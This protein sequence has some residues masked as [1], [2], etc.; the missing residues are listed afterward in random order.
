MEAVQT[1]QLKDVE[2][3]GRYRSPTCTQPSDTERKTKMGNN[4]PL[5][6]VGRARADKTPDASQGDAKS[7][8]ESAEPASQGDAK[9]ERK[10][11][12]PLPEEREDSQST[13]TLLGLG[14][15]D[16]PARSPT[17]LL[18]EPDHGFPRG[19]T[20]SS[21][22]YDTSSSS[23]SEDSDSLN[24][25][26]RESLAAAAASSTE[27]GYA[28]LERAL[29]SHITYE[30]DEMAA[31]ES[32]ATERNK[33]RERA[34]E[35]T[36]LRV[37]KK[38]KA[39]HEARLVRET[40]TEAL[41]RLEAEPAFTMSAL[42][43]AQ[44][45]QAT[46]LT[47]PA[48]HYHKFADEQKAPRPAAANLTPA[49]TNNANAKRRLAYKYTNTNCTDHQC[50]KAHYHSPRAVDIITPPMVGGQDREIEVGGNRPGAVETVIEQEAK[51]VT[52]SYDPAHLVP[53]VQPALVVEK[54]PPVADLTVAVGHCP[55]RGSVK[56][57][58]LSNRASQLIGGMLWYG[59][60][61]R[62]SSATVTTM[63]IKQA[64]QSALRLGGF[65]FG[66][67]KSR[68]MTLD[69]L[70][71]AGYKTIIKVEYYP[72]LLVRLKAMDWGKACPI[73]MSGKPTRTLMNQFE[74]FITV[75]CKEYVSHPEYRVAVASATKMLAYI[76]RLEAALL[77]GMV[78]GKGGIAYATAGAP[79]G[80]A[81]DRG[82]LKTKDNPVANDDL[83][84]DNGDFVKKGGIWEENGDLKTDYEFELMSTGHNTHWAGVSSNMDS[85]ASNPRHG[86]N[87]LRRLT[88]KVCPE[89][90]GF[91]E[92][93][94]TNQL[95]NLEVAAA[96]MDKHWDQV[97]VAWEANW[98]PSEEM[99]ALAVENAPSA[100]VKLY[101]YTA[102]YRKDA[103][104]WGT[105]A[106][107]QLKNEGAQ[108]VEMA[109]EGETKR[110]FVNLGVDT[111]INTGQA[112]RFLKDALTLPYEH[113]DCR[114]TFVKRV[115]TVSLDA[116]ALAMAAPAKLF[117]AFVHSDDGSFVY[118]GTDGI[119]HRF[120]IDISKCDR[121]QKNPA[122]Q[123]F[124]RLM[125]NFPAM[126]KSTC[127]AIMRDVKIKAKNIKYP[128]ERDIKGWMQVLQLYLPSG[129][130]IT[131]SI[132]T[133]IEM[134]IMNEIYRYC[135]ALPDGVAPTSA[136]I[137]KVAENLGYKIKCF[138]RPSAAQCTF[139]KKHVANTS[140][141]IQYPGA[142]F[143]AVK[144]V[145]AL[146]SVLRSAF[147]CRGDI[148]NKGK[149][150]LTAPCKS[151]TR[152]IIASLTYDTEIPMLEA[153]KKQ[154]ALTAYERFTLT[155]KLRDQITLQVAREYEYK[156][157]ESTN[158]AKVVV[159]NSSYLERYF[160]GDEAAKERLV[161][162]VGKLRFG[163]MVNTQ[164]TRHVMAMDYDLEDR[165]PV[166]Q[167]DFARYNSSHG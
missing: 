96:R 44:C 11:A 119:L 98:Q 3:P 82:I 124:S 134:I 157:G 93:L 64:Q 19:Q 58:K 92:M 67:P 132:N 63:T 47:C 25:R 148:P 8:R 48:A 72:A 31:A 145:P 83:F 42:L 91:H 142:K 52:A 57:P 35:K 78:T 155:S 32:L 99:Q 90:P 6:T 7:E 75:T 5:L 105:D 61:A 149:D 107:L 53:E 80:T 79:D 68:R 160:P 16:L 163:V 150:N 81:V 133:F 29:A 4:D 111:T 55:V 62:T 39:K 151:R 84:I 87:S 154:F 26:G 23:D 138:P 12:A 94:R 113:E 37:G 156:T 126:W 136:G 106:G 120:D 162:A 66:T 71:T 166:Y 41:N 38:G 36:L 109:A 165:M 18:D 159:S 28:R 114:I 43:W 103:G 144:A 102:Q 74:Q 131:T 15:L 139:L 60:A 128:R 141:A 2:T 69:L 20:S 112:Y 146:G 65:K 49:Q 27:A 22:G 97:R 153:L 14:R 130:V 46:R 117:E 129:H 34:K 54:P 17:C 45:F 127:D 143:Q 108:K 121:S 21:G 104:H 152:G 10:S 30:R 123:S 73:D 9:T 95:L 59:G 56:L 89:L 137:I 40:A 100:K 110:M 13:A 101:E 167:G 116:W 88:G 70:R 147:R 125:A 158:L 33:R 1:R 24:S 140:D 115:N 135:M 161:E 51:V 86:R 76:E 118:R 50:N 122:F 77:E 85:L 164:E